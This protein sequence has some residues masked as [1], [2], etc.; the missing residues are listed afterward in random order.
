[1]SW[2]QILAAPTPPAPSNDASAAS[3]TGSFDTWWARPSYACGSP[4]A[5]SAAPASIFCHSAPSTTAI[6]PAGTSTTS[7]AAA[8][9]PAAFI[10]W[11]YGNPFSQLNATES[12]AYWTCCY[13]SWTAFRWSCGRWS[14]ADKI[15]SRLK[16]CFFASEYSNIS[17]LICQLTQLLNW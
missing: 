12:V 4:P 5:D 9:L 11:G 8:E 14:V 10:C 3:S 6:P 2:F 17:E 7:I 15:A 13:A 16:N 1:M